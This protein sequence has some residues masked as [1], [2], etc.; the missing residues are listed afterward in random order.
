MPKRRNA[1]K[2]DSD[3]EEY[4]EDPHDQEQEVDES[5]ESQPKKRRGRVAIPDRWTRVVHVQSLGDA[6]PRIFEIAPDIMLSK[7]LPTL[8]RTL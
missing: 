4:K 1:P 2:P 5:V 8:T 7:F 6:E 3:L